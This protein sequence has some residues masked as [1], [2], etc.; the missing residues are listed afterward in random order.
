MILRAEGVPFIS[1][2][3]VMETA[4]GALKRSKEEVALR[5]LCVVLVAARGSGLEEEIVERVLKSFELR[6]HLTP[7]ELAFVLDD[8]PSRH[9]RV[10]FSWR[11]EAA[12]ALLWALGF[13]AQLGKPAQMCDTDFIASTVSGRNE[14]SVHRRRRTSSHRRH[15]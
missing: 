6:P 1:H 3:P 13:V 8:S 4:A 10:Q 12:W 7:K 9:D 11:H 15:S 5:T 14:V 2:L